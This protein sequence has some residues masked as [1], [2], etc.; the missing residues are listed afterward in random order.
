MPTIF[1]P[2]VIV[3]TTEGINGSITFRRAT[4]RQMIA[5]RMGHRPL[6]HALAL[7]IVG[8]LYSTDKYDLM[9]SPPKTP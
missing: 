9:P 4:H 8:I 7:P 3:W 5:A 6:R 2:A 1:A